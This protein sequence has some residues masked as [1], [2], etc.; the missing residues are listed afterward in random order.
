[1]QNNETVTTLVIA[2][3][4]G[5][6]FPGVAALI[7]S[8]HSRRIGIRSDER[9]TR[10]DVVSEYKNMNEVLHRENL[11][12]RANY[13]SLDARYR[14]ALSYVAQLRSAIEQREDP[15]PPDYPKDL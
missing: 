12:L 9:Q 4:S 7:S 11:E 6:L 10:S 3:L 13:D 5:S 8:V 1:M 14:R 15:P 2:A